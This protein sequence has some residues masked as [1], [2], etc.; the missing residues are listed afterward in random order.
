M[1]LAVLR[2][3]NEL[4]IHV[5]RDV[6]V[7][8][9]DDPPAAS[10]ITPALTVVKQQIALLAYRGVERLVQIIQGESPPLLERIPTELV[11][12]ESTSRPRS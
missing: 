2:G 5:P 3:L 10:H 4:G 1:G 12:R 11:I 7:V 9:F 6:S 8:S